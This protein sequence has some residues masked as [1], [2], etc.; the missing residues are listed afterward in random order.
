[1]CRKYSLIFARTCWDLLCGI[2]FSFFLIIGFCWFPF[3]YM[4]C[5]VWM[6]VYVFVVVVLFESGF[7]FMYYNN[8]I[9]LA[10]WI[11]RMRKNCLITTVALCTWSRVFCEKRIIISLHYQNIKNYWKKHWHKIQILCS[12]R[13][14]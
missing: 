9:S 11:C 1:M 10:L 13:S 6:C 14:V 8:V 7:V 2:P 12:L 4:H 5:L 3:S